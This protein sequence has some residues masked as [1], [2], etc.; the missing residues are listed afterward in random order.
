MKDESGNERIK[1]RSNCLKGWRWGIFQGHK[2]EET[3]RSPS[4]KPFM[5]L[6]S[7]F[8]GT[9]GARMTTRRERNVSM[10]TCR[11]EV[12]ASDN[13]GEDISDTQVLMPLL[14]FQRMGW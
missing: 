8:P 2:D 10:L 13:D 12:Y 1:S 6:F 4:P 9:Q 3:Y 14:Q 7:S 11:A 5:R